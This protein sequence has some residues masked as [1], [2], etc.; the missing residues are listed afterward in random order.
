MSIDGAHLRSGLL[1]L[2][3]F[4]QEHA[5]RGISC[6]ARR[7]AH[8]AGGAGIALEMISGIGAVS[9]A[10]GKAVGA[11]VIGAVRDGLR[12]VAFAALF[13]F[14]RAALGLALLAA[15]FRIA[16]G[17]PAALRVLG[18]PRSDFVLLVALFGLATVRFAAL[19]FFLGVELGLA[20]RFPGVESR[21]RSLFRSRRALSS[22]SFFSSERIS[23]I[24]LD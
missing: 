13:A 9:E 17:R 11:G 24:S 8:V 19:R 3:R 4:W 6:R 23:F 16:T 14:P 7:S 2:R 12:D 21:V 18:A 1:R 15:L 22:C 20:F 10:L 5:A